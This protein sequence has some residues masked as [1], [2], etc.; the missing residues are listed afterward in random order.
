MPKRTKNLSLIV[1]LISSLQKKTDEIEW[2]NP[3]DP[4]LEDLLRQLNHYKQQDRKG[5]L[6]EPNF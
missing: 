5:E 6:Y 1:D 4:R 2:E 3:G